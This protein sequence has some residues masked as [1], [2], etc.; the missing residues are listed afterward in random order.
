MTTPSLSRLQF[1]AWK[2]LV[3]L[4]HHW[5]IR[6]SSVLESNNVTCFLFS[7]K[8]Y[9]NHDKFA[10]QYEILQRILISYLI[11]KL[12]RLRYIYKTVSNPTNPNFSRQLR[13][14]ATVWACFCTL[15]AYHAERESCEKGH[16]KFGVQ[17][18]VKLV[19][20]WRKLYS[21]QFKIQRC[22]R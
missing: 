10:K 12:H 5:Y 22:V 8:S 17:Q 14:Y 3:S 7:P 2:Q 9:I 13:N 6:C 21:R 19:L 16:E 20:N 11:M 18:G 1:C 15:D 4:Y